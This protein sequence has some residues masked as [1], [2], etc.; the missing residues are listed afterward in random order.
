MRLAESGAKVALVEARRVGSLVSGHTTAKATAQHGLISQNVSSDARVPWLQA[1]A[2]ALDDLEAWAIE[3][4]PSARFSRVDSHVYTSEPASVRAVEQE[5]AL[6]REAGLAGSLLDAG[7]PDG[8]LVAAR[9]DQQAQFD[10]IG[11]I[12]GLLDQAP[13]ELS[14]FEET[15]ITRVD[16]ESGVVVMGCDEGEVRAGAAVIASHVPFFDPLLYM[17]RLFQE[18]SYAFE[19]HTETEVPLGTWYT[20][21]QDSY[22]WRS[23]G[24]GDRK[25][26]IVSGLGHKAG[27]G[28]DERTHYSRLEE[29]T[30]RKF[31]SE[32]TFLRHW[33]TQDAYTPDGL[34][35]IGKMHG[36]ERCFM[37][38]G[39]QAW[40]MTTSAVASEVLAEQIGGG[41]H[42]LSEVVG[43]ARGGT[44]GVAKLAVENADFLAKAFSHEFAQHG[45]PDELAPGSGR[46][47][48]T[49]AGH[50]AVMKEEDGT[51][52]TLDAHC[53]HMRCAVEFNEAEGTWDCPCHGSRFYGNGDW[54]HGPSRRALEPRNEGRAKSQ[55]G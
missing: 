45:D 41:Q 8:M 5:A 24:E 19:V 25:R 17:T 42:Y 49:D 21:D 20:E 47:M 11:L 40:G 4:G 34:P 29:M 54:L 37:A 28:R 22:A 10:P 30:R 50:V 39:F 52:R 55:D 14:V 9:L 13:D 26:L 32:T 46:A 35:Y 2:K 3:A 7:L 44:A 36:R 6:Y 18:R 31:G 53:T 48:R 43:P 23:V 12:D 38:S 27:Q 16:E 1:N 15:L 33:S 51:L